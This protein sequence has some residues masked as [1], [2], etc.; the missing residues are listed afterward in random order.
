MTQQQIIELVV[1]MILKVNRLRLVREQREQF[2]AQGC[3]HQANP[4]YLP[5]GSGFQGQTT[6]EVPGARQRGDAYGQESLGPGHRGNYSDTG[7]I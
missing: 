7:F 1:P 4:E 3:G 5:Q 6:R 2:H